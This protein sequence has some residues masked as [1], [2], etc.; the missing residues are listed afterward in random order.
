MSSYLHEYELKVKENEKIVIDIPQLGHIF[1]LAKFPGG[2][3]SWGV[4]R[5]SQ[6]YMTRMV[7]DE[8]TM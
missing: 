7:D 8:H 5:E 3:W 2:A 1:H 4:D 6:F